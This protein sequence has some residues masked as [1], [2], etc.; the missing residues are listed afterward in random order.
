M[1]DAPVSAPANR[2]Y[3]WEL[4][5]RDVPPWRHPCRILAGVTVKSEDGPSKPGDT[6]TKL[7]FSYNGRFC[8]FHEPTSEVRC[9]ELVARPGWKKTAGQLVHIKGDKPGSER[10]DEHQ[11]NIDRHGYENL[12]VMCAN[13]HRLVDDLEPERFPAH[14]LRRMKQLAESDERNVI[15]PPFFV[16]D[17]TWLAAVARSAIIEYARALGDVSM[18]DLSLREI[19]DRLGGVTVSG[20]AELQ[21][22]TA[23]G[24]EA[25]ARDLSASGYT[26]STGSLEVELER[27]EL[28]LDGVA[29]APSITHQELAPP[30]NHVTHARLDAGA[31]GSASVSGRS[32]GR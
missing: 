4:N 12:M 25:N 10:Y 21:P 24:T 2:T 26:T 17:Q 16:S 28:P 8:G 30:E 11:P 6:A 29:V 1:V 20:E 3:P 18:P 7:V 31:G 5:E 13:H 23:T 9:A 27:A 19:K 22:V 15:D 14:V 32:P